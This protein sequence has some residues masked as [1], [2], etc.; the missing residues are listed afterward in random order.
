MQKIHKHQ[1]QGQQVYQH[2]KHKHHSVLWGWWG[3][4]GVRSPVEEG[5]R[6]VEEGV[7][8]ITHLQGKG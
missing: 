4:Q 7:E 8:G 2:H 5:V 3:V 6:G 1:W